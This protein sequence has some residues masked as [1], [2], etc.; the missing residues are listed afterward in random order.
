MMSGDNQQV[1]T[2]VGEAVGIDRAMGELLPEDKVAAIRELGR[3]GRLTC[4]VGDGVNDAPAMAN[5]TI[6]IAMGAAGSTVASRAVASV[7]VRSFSEAAWSWAATTARAV[8]CAISK[9]LRSP[10]AAAC[11]AE[12]YR[13]MIWAATQTQQTTNCH[14]IK[15]TMA[16]VMLLSK[17]KAA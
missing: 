2:A 13:M 16:S 6:G 4:M 1:A 12:T 9:F 3:G 15:K 10:L 8:S 7:C 5:A 14:E 17:L 11:A